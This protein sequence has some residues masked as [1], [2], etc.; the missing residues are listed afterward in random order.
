[1]FKTAGWSRPAFLI[2]FVLAPGAENYFYQSLQFHGAEA[3]LRPGVLI[4]LGLILLA[5][6]LPVI[7][8]A[9]MRRRQTHEVVDSAPSPEE[10]LL[11]SR[12]FGGVDLLLLLMMAAVGIWALFDI[13]GLMPLGKAFPTLAAFITLLSVIA[14]VFNGWRRGMIRVKQPATKSIAVVLGFFVL[15]GISAVLGFVCTAVI[16]CLGFQRIVARKSLGFSAL[17]SLG[18]AVFLL[19]MQHT[20]NLHYPTG[21]LDDVVLPMVPF[22]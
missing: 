15:I 17:F 6:F 14:V 20:M 11:E 8:K 2:G 3:F 1:L 5:F 13:S 9:I 4:I 16:F 12:G 22:L 21:L 7:R 19:G 10:D 18:V